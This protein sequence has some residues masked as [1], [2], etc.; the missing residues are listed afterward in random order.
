MDGQTAADMQRDDQIAATESGAIRAHIDAAIRELH[1][2]MPGV[3]RSF[4]PVTQTA[5]VQPALKTV[6][7][8]EAEPF[9]YPVCT[10]VPVVFQEG[11]NFVLTFPVRA[12]DE[13]LLFFSERAIDFWWDR[14]GTQL[15]SEVRFHDMSDGFAQVGV[16]SRPR[17]LQNVATDAAEL[18]TR[19]G[20]VVLRIEGNKIVLDAATVHVGSSAGS[21]PAALGQTLQ[22][23]L[24]LV[25]NHVHTGVTTGGGVSG[26]SAE[27]ATAPNV[28][29]E[30]A[31]VK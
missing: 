24:N 9:E 19:D 11:G 22:T 14:G 16:R 12:G 20:T 4:D 21:E 1:T 2:C 3:I 26:P 18:R 29:A 27:L 17:F 31:R 7:V 8:D 5:S 10:D 23:Y 28:L 6:F 25:A 13:C 30:R 15:P